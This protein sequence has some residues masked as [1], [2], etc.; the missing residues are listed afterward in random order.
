MLENSHQN[1][2]MEPMGQEQKRVL[3]GA[4][5]GISGA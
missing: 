1:F 2:L 3:L 4:N 5:N